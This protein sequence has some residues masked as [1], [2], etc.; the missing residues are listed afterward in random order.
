MLKQNHPIIL[1]SKSPRRQQLL[2]G[3]GLTFDIKTNPIE[4]IYSKEMD[5]YEVPVYLAKLKS[6]PFLNK[7]Y[8]QDVVISSDTVVIVE[9]KILGKPKD[10]EDAIQ[11]LLMLSQKTHEVVTGVCILK[12]GI[13]H[14]FSKV[15]RVTFDAVSESEAAYYVNT[16][17]PMDKAGSY[18]IQEWIGYTKVSKI[19]GCYYNVMG[20][21]LRDLYEKLKQ[22]KVISV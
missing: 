3:I 5:V 16:Y 14:A 12:E 21:P 2:L 15:T 20:F 7:R 13:R 8:D 10:A 19:E 4:E 17:A 11:M 18:G 22:L 1:A 9:G 6:T